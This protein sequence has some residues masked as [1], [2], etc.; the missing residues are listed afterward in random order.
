[1]TSPRLPR[2]WARRMTRA[3]VAAH[4]SRGWGC[5]K[6][7]HRDGVAAVG[8]VRWYRW[9]GQ[10]RV[11]ERFLCDEHAAAYARRYRI[12]IDPEWPPDAPTD[13]AA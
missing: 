10:V 13:G 11:S 2:S 6:R 4:I 1:M 8:F 12:P 3:E 9:G 7:G 5:E